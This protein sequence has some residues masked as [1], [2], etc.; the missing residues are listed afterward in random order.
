MIH[1]VLANKLIAL[2]DELLL[3]NGEPVLLRCERI[4]FK[5]KLTDGSEHEVG[6]MCKEALES[7]F[8]ETARQPL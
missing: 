5:C 3:V 4:A 6:G 7:F 1:K 8:E 2:G